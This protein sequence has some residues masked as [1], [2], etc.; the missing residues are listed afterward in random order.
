MLSDAIWSRCDNRL[1]NTK[2]RINK[3]T[4]TPAIESFECYSCI[5]LQIYL[6]QWSSQVES[7]LILLTEIM[8]IIITKQ[9]DVYI[10][11]GDN[12]VCLQSLLSN[13]IVEVKTRI[14]KLE[15]VSSDWPLVIYHWKK[16]PLDSLLLASAVAIATEFNTNDRQ[17]FLSRACLFQAPVNTH[18]D[19]NDPSECWQLRWSR[20]G[21]SL[22]SSRLADRLSKE[23]RCSHQQQ[24]TGSCAINSRSRN[25]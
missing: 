8:I 3:K 25:D 22:V 12:I 13:M 11:Y 14:G 5:C 1:S 2:I 19:D 7:S 4:H 24:L 18:D 15:I 23:P 9:W 10:H 6:D 21:L 17:Q 20:S 16:Q